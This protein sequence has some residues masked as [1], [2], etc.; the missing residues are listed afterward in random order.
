MWKNSLTSI[1]FS[2]L[3]VGSLSLIGLVKDARTSI[4]QYALTGCLAFF[5][6]LPLI[7]VVRN[8]SNLRT[9]LLFFALG[10]LPSLILLICFYAI[11]TRDPYY[12][13]AP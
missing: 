3:M 12:V 11:L 4:W 7:R 9:W 8:E 2:G 13:P 1:C 5:A 6:S 10:L